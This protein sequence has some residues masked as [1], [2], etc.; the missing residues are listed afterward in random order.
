MKPNQR[1]SGFT[2]IEV[3]ATLVIVSVL[4]TVAYVYFGK[5]FLES[6]TP[7]TRLKQ[8][9]ALH[10]V[11]ENITADYNVFPKWRSGTNYAKDAPVIPTYFNGHYYKASG[12][13]SSATNEPEWPTTSAGTVVD[14]TI[15]WT[16][17][18]RLRDLVPL[19][20][21]TNPKN[22]KQRIGDEGSVQSTTNDYCKNSDGT[23]TTYT[24]VKN[25]FVRFV[26][27]VEQDDTSGNNKILKA[28]LQNENGETLTALFFSD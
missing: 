21:S 17:S 24:V 11:M 26:N 19:Y 28:T 10:R 15:T 16:E 1:S 4:G 9:A 18:G 6:V 27:D 12:G 14:G 22:L 2:L 8:T 5:G 13:T 20:S 23:H 7:V 25:R 3:I